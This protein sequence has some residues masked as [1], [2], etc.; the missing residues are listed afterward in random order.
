MKEIELH[1]KY[2][3][4]RSTIVDDED[5]EY[6]NQF[7]WYVSKKGYVETGIP[8]KLQ[9]D[10][11]AKHMQMQRMLMLNSITEK[12]QLVDH[13]NRDKLDNRKENLR[14]CT[15]SESNLL[16]FYKIIII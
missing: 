8:V 14:L 9:E 15:M 5:Y 11:P 12:G 4:G 13:K 7:S 2:S 1:G 16:I 3:D 6:L 10:Y